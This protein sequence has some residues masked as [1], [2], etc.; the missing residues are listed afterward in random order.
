MQKNKWNIQGWICGEDYKMSKKI[1]ILSGSPRKKDGYRLIQ[2][3]G[4]KLNKKGKVELE[5]IKLS[6]LKVN[7]CVGCMK[8]FDK[9]EE[10]CPF[11]D[12]IS[13]VV[14]KLIS[15]DGII[16]LSPVYA[17]SITGVMK[18]VIDRMSYMFHRPELVAKPSIT[19]VTTGGGGIKPTQE[20]LKLVGRGFGCNLLGEL[21][22]ISPLYYSES[23]LYNQKYF[24]KVSKK[25]DIL[26]E[27]LYD[28]IYCDKKPEPS[29]KDLYMFH[30]LRSK[31]YLSKADYEYW[32]TKGWLK[33]K[34]YYDVRLN[35]CK[36][37]FGSLL[38]VLIRVMIK[39]YMGNTKN[40]N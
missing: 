30:G 36:L 34:Y 32:N 27:K 25:L 23:S 20:Y 7:N 26:V 37:L 38:D 15:C 10:Y 35:P 16:F 29:Y 8:C 4:E 31:T 22:V 1:I 17:L 6:D 14:N 13:D 21:S 39:K 19:I 11:K 2:S 28:G 5:Y 9:G 40:V 24:N 3:I 12:D 18:K 33:S